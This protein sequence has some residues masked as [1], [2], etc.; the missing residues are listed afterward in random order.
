MG[1]IRTK[2]TEQFRRQSH[3]L[4]FQPLQRPAKGAA[5]VEATDLL[6]IYER[7]LTPTQDCSKDTLT[8]PMPLVCARRVAG[9]IIAAPITADA[10]IRNNFLSDALMVIFL[11]RGNS[12]TMEL[13][14]L[15]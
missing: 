8:P 7:I 10:S 6:L 4:G 3:A 15:S 11:S 13:P 5:V 1:P 14:R 2:R 12:Y 9:W